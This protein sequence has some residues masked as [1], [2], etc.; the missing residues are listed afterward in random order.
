MVL[1]LQSPLVYWTRQ[2]LNTHDIERFFTA[3]IAYNP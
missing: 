2:I 1:P 3:Q